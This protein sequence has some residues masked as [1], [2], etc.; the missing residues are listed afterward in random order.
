MND[1]E[2]GTPVDRIDELAGL[3]RVVADSVEIA[4]PAGTWT[5]VGEIDYTPA[6]RQ[7]LTHDELG[8]D[9]ARAVVYAMRLRRKRAIR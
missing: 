9:R 2:N 1:F 3:L 7:L 6:H 4:V 5:G 8:G